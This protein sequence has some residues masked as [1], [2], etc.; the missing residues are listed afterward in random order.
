MLHKRST[1]ITTETLRCARY[2]PCVRM[3]IA[4]AVSTDSGALYLFSVLRFISVSL[5]LGGSGQ[6]FYALV[7]ST[8]S[9]QPKGGIAGKAP[10]TRKWAMVRKKMCPLADLDV[11]MAQILRYRAV[12]ACFPVHVPCVACLIAFSTRRVRVCAVGVRL[13][14]CCWQCC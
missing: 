14:L 10:A 5:R 8:N 2:W 1:I 7:A 4:L 3:M 11:Q 12:V 6:M 13:V 9:Q